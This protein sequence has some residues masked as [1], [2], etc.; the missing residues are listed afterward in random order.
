[1]LR[2]PTLRPKQRVEAHACR[3][4]LTDN[5]GVGRDSGSPVCDDYPAGDHSHDHLVD[6]EHLLP[7]TMNR[8]QP[9]PRVVGQ[10]SPF[11]ATIR[12]TSGATGS[13]SATRAKNGSRTSL[14]RRCCF[15]GSG[16]V[17]STSTTSAPSSGDPRRRPRGSIRR[18]GSTISV[19][20][21][22]RSHWGPAS[23]PLTYLAISVPAL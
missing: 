12:G 4:N 15:P 2:N 20:P 11:A 8:Q 16:V 3:Y 10:L 9:C 6:P 19:I 22:R 23:Q 13:S 18:G 5:A 1:P 14:V 7:L 21:S 17:T